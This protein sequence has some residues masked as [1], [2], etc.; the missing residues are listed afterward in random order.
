MDAVV[1]SLNVIYGVTETRPWWK[2]KLTIVGLT[3]T[4]AALII[5]ALVLV[6]YGGKIGQVMADHIGL[7]EA[8]RAAWK[9]MQWEILFFV[10]LFC[11]YVVLILAS[12]LDVITYVDVLIG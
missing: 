3:V 4:L 7:G 9:I 10:M 8:F 12:D 5:V 6:L 1:V 11:F 2:Q